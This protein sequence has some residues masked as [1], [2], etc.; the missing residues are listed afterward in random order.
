M[1]VFSKKKRSSIMAAVKGA[2]TNPEITVRALVRRM[3]CRFRSQGIGLPGKPDIVFPQLRK[4]IF[5]NGCFWHNHK[6]CKRAVLPQTNRLFWKQKIVGNV[7][8]DKVVNKKLRRMGWRVLTVWQC[9][10]KNLSILKKRIAL[11]I[12]E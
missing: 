7:T 4:V 3:G 9:Q 2:D 5:V 8:R 11:F 1:D 6:N 12:K 10:T